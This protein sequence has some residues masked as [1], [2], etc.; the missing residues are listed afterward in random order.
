M[1]QLVSNIKKSVQK[2]WRIVQNIVTKASFPYDGLPL[3]YTFFCAQLLKLYTYIKPEYGD[4]VSQGRFHLYM[5]YVYTVILKFSNLTGRC[6]TTFT[7]ILN[8]C[9]K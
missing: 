1:K 8:F 3:P 9:S 6:G 7:K 4:L 2:I 5:K